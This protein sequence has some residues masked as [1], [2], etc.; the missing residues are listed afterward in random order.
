VLFEGELYAA[1]SGGLLT[2]IRLGADPVESVRLIGH[3]P[4]L[5]QL[6]L[7]GASAGD[8]LVAPRDEVPH[9]RAR[10][11]RAN[12]GAGELA[13]SDALLTAYA[14]PKQLR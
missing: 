1:T 8:E 4:S 9:G 6:G 2:R 13:P 5:Q 14:D 10:H 12:E 3:N 7:V 11:D